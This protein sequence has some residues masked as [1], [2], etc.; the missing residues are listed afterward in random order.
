MR[1]SESPS[2]EIPPPGHPTPPHRPEIPPVPPGGSPVVP[3]MIDDDN[4]LGARLRDQR[5]LLLS[6]PIDEPT[7]TRVA[8]E[9]MLF[10]GRSERPVEL[11]INSDGGPAAEVL[12]LIDVIGLMRA[13]VATRCIGRAVG[14]AA[15]VLASGTEGRSATANATISL[16]LAD[17]HDV[18]GSAVD[19]QRRL[20][21]ISAARS[22]IAEQLAATTR[23]SADEARRALDEGGAMAAGAARS[24]G[25]IDEVAAR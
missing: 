24:A 17:Q 20:D 25:V 8:A 21:E 14:T 6:G 3:F 19:I 16:R 13:P 15:V 4:D 7:V 12:G 5:R 11:I 10:D 22:R 23:L 2:P 1:S 9:L 18:T